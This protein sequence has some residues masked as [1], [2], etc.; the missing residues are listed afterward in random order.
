MSQSSK[1]PDYMHFLATYRYHP[2][3]NNYE[4][5]IH[6]L[7]I[8]TTILK[9]LKLRGSFLMFSLSV[10]HTKMIKMTIYDSCD[11]WIVS[12][13]SLRIRGVL[14]IPSDPPASSLST[15]AGKNEV[16]GGRYLHGQ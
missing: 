3:A 5:L 10:I 12:N 4:Y 15:F 13:N 14:S 11:S 1:I 16:Y 8:S 7:M 6:Y 9:T 2:L